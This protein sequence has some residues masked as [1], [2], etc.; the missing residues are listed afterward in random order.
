MCLIWRLL[1]LS[2]PK[3][4]V[5][6]TAMKTYKFLAKCYPN[7][8]LAADATK[9]DDKAAAG[10]RRHPLFG[11]S[12]LPGMTCRISLHIIATRDLELMVFITVLFAMEK[13]SATISS[14]SLFEIRLH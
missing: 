3:I 6:T 9:P 2:Y 11:I 1:L 4:I 13:H 12:R 8:Y 7:A 10:I 5:I 14:H